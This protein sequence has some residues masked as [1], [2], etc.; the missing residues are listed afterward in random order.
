MLVV[1]LTPIWLGG[2][3]RINEVF[4]EII[5][6]SEFRTVTSFLKHF[7]LTKLFFEKILT[8]FN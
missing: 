7:K 8:Y 5:N 1:N 6:E 3:V 4:D 2:M